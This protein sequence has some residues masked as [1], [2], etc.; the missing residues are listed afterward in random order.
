[1]RRVSKRLDWR[2]ALRGWSVWSCVRG[3][4]LRMSLPAR[5]LFLI[6]RRVCSWWAPCVRLD[7]AAG[8]DADRLPC[9]AWCAELDLE[10]RLRL[11]VRAVGF[12][13]LLL[14]RETIC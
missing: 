5:P 6:P 4:L 2:A 11:E 12:C 7:V 1:M 14:L 3:V 10:L 9:R 8:A 13:F